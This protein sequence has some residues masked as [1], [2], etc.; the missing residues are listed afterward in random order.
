MH[1][2]IYPLNI[3]QK[4]AM[5]VLYHLVQGIEAKKLWKTRELSQLDQFLPAYQ[6][7]NLPL[8][9]APTAE[10]ALLLGFLIDELLL[11]W[12]DV[13]LGF[14]CCCLVLVLVVLIVIQ[15]WVVFLG[16]SPYF[17]ALLLF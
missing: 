13:D 10:L 16:V 5:G 12:L 1:V 14:R 6:T 3:T 9:Q 17:V 15:P 4:I 2:H 7:E 8:A 11:L